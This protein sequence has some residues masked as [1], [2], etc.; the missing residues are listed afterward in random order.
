VRAIVVFAG[1]A[2]S[3]RCTAVLVGRKRTTMDNTK[4]PSTCTVPCLRR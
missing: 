4:A 2:T 1:R 3:V